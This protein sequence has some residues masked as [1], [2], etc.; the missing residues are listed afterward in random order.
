MLIS[1]IFCQVARRRGTT[2]LLPHCR[3][4]GHIA[5]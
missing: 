3:V 4:L 1:Y 5:C 2:R